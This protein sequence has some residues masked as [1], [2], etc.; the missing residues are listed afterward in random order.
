MEEMEDQSEAL[1]PVA[2]C[3][4][5]LSS[6][7]R[8]PMP[9]GVFKNPSRHLV[10]YQG[11]IFDFISFPSGPQLPRSTEEKKSDGA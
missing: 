11:F 4:Y 1:G 2:V 8:V 6:S 3:H 10:E 9:T 5:Y 7:E